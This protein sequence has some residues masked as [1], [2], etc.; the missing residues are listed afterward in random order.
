MYKIHQMSPPIKVH[1]LCSVAHYHKKSTTQISATCT[2]FPP[3][4]QNFKGNVLPLHAITTYVVCVC[5]ELK[6]H[7]PYIKGSSQL[8][9]PT[10]ITPCEELPVPTE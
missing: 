3:R 4:Q 7:V 9:T 1:V 5:V 8:H 6:F 10:A 2:Y